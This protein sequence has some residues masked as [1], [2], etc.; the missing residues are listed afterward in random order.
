MHRTSTGPDLPLAMSLLL[1]SV[2][3]NYRGGRGGVK[4]EESLRDLRPVQGQAEGHADEHAHLFAGDGVR[5]A[6]LA[7]AAAA[8]RAPARQLLDARAERAVRG[9]VAIHR[10]RAGRRDQRGI[11]G[12]QHED[13]HL[14]A[15]DG[16]GWA[17]VAAAAAAH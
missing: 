5:W 11:Q 10:R 2:L 8:D 13:R 17:V 7:A 3:A 14:R 12:A 9:N 6:V 1:I 4:G 15:R 16:T